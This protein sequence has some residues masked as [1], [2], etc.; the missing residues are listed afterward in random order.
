MAD[1]VPIFKRPLSSLLSSY[2]PISITP[3]LSEIYER[4]ISSRLSSYMNKTGLFP[5][6]QYSYRKDLGT[7]DALLDVIWAGQRAL[8]CD[9]E[10]AL[11]PIDFSAAF[12]C[13]SCR[14]VV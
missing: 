3:V 13:Q 11:V 14:A 6:H 4:L 12:D 8:E 10:L 2:R 7:C 1:I 5:T 9:G